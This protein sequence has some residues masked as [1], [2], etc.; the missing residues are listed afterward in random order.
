MI[1]MNSKF[2]FTHEIGVLAKDNSELTKFFFNN[3]TR[4]GEYLKKRL[5]KNSIYLL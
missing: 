2:F 4:K 1:K 5:I 3:M